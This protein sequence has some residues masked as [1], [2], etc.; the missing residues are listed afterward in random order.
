MSA[1]THVTVRKGQ[2]LV[3]GD[4]RPSFFAPRET[5][6][7]VIGQEGAW[8]AVECPGGPRWMQLADAV[9]RHTSKPTEVAPPSPVRGMLN[10]IYA[11]E[12]HGTPFANPDAPAPVGIYGQVAQSFAQVG[13]T[14]KAAVFDERYRVSDPATEWSKK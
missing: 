11:R 3:D 7:T 10:E 4:G 2:P 8:L 12:M 9:A 14:E 5:I 1:I 13:E 6:L